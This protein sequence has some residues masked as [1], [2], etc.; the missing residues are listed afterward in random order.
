MRDKKTID[1][2][3]YLHL[4]VVTRERKEFKFSNIFVYLLK[5]RILG[6]EEGGGIAT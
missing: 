4:F 1:K 3:H 5:R 6:F 2:L